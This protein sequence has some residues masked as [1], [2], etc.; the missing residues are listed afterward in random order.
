MVPGGLYS[1]ENYLIAGAGGNSLT[2]LA[3]RQVHV[4]SD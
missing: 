3:Q 2:L 1:I 4:I